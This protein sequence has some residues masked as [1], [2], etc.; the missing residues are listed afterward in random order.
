MMALP[1]V[2]VV[3]GWRSVKILD[4]STRSSFPG[5]LVP[6]TGSKQRAFIENW[7]KVDFK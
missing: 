2:A 5:W 6:G 7:K 4:S 3:K 1:G